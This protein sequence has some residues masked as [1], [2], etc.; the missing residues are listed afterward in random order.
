[1]KAPGDCV[2]LFRLSGPLRLF[3]RFGVVLTLLGLLAA[4]SRGS[5]SNAKAE[6]QRVRVAVP[7]TAADAVE[8]TVPV[9]LRVIGNVQ[10]YS[11][12]AV[13]AQV[14]GELQTVHFKEGQEVKKGE[15]LF[16]ID[17]RPF[18]ARLKQAEA[19]LAKGKAQLQNAR[20][21]AER[22]GSVVKQG[23]VAEEQYDQIVANAAAL[24][25]AVRADEAAVESARL[26]LKYCSIRS[27]LNGYVGDLKVDQGNVV[28]ANDNEK[29]LVTINQVSPIYVA[30]SI[31]EQELPDVRRYMAQG[32][33]E[34]LATVPGQDD[35]PARG[36]L[37]FVDNTVDAATGTIQLKATFPNDDRALWPGQFVNVVLTLTSMPNVVVVPSQAVQTGQQGQ[38]V[39]II[40]PDLTVDYRPVTIARTIDE[41]V[42]IQEGLKPGEK[43]VADGHLRLAP[44]ALVKVVDGKENS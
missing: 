42:V 27:P 26:E 31:P 24:E 3:C 39:Y 14:S 21:Q 2:P 4:C 22:Y 5:S 35:K 20:K 16:T 11:T 10:P 32:P 18:E 33:L 8:K 7:V 30:F 36:T 23:Y 41:E 15:L 37:S 19:N 28:K 1:M 34:V 40:K 13:T 6:E 25:A 43:V 29:P 44:G 9:Q 12:V 17:T 38:Y